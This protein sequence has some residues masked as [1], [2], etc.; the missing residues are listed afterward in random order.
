MPNRER[1]LGMIKD[2]KARD[3]VNLQFQTAYVIG[4]KYGCYRNPNSS[5]SFLNLGLASYYIM[6]D[7]YNAEKALRR[8]VA[9]SPFD[10]HV[11]QNWKF[12]RDQFPDKALGYHPKGRVEGLSTVKGAKKKI[13][14][15][16][17]I[18]EDSQ[19]AGWVRHVA[20]QMSGDDIL[21]QEDSYWYNPATGEERLEQPNWQVEWDIRQRR[22]RCDGNKDGLEHYFD[23]LTSCHFQFH[24]VSRTYI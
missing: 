13:V 17:D 14:H 22:S 11:I 10:E 16:K 3:P 6:D 15:G 23:P 12:L 21:M 18:F 7:L 4:Y 20:P 5:Y 19:W 9:M 1:A 8:A 24:E 2:A